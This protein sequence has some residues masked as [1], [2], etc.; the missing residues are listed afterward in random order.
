M[1]TLKP[2]CELCDLDLPANALNALICSYECTFCEHCVTKVLENVCPNCGGEFT[3]RPIRPLIAH[4]KGVSL[5]H[6]PGS[7]VRVHSQYSKIEIRAFA[8]AIKS[9]QA[10]LR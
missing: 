2:N 10:D 5:E 9:I 3:R 1:L 6:N 8:Q 4:R 7:A